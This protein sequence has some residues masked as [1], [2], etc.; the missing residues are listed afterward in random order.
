MVIRTVNQNFA[1]LACACAELRNHIRRVV[2]YVVFLEKG[3]L[4]I[5]RRKNRYYDEEQAVFRSMFFFF[6]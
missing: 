3:R 4:I 5:R 2:L 6:I 1:S